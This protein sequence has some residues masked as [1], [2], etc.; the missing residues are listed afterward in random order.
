V[1]TLIGLEFI[2]KQFNM[3][4]SEVADILGISR[5]TVNDW[6]KERSNIPKKRLEELSDYFRL[7]EH[8]FQKKLTLGEE[9]KIKLSKDM[10]SRFDDISEE[11]SMLDV[12]ALQREFRQS[13]HI[14][15]TYCHDLDDNTEPDNEGHINGLIREAAKNHFYTKNQLDNIA[16]YEEVTIDD[17]NNAMFTT[18]H[19]MDSLSTLIKKD[20]SKALLEYMKDAIDIWWLEDEEKIKLHN[21][22]NQYILS[23]FYDDKWSESLRLKK[24]EN[25]E[26]YIELDELLKKHNLK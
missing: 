9:E 1:N 3:S 13:L 8:L 2:V 11:A 21:I 12:I 16:M 23:L 4:F 26:F 15:K 7:P 17:K 25:K 6:T 5:K 14:L 10:G 22:L 20:N 18:S 19:F 24:G